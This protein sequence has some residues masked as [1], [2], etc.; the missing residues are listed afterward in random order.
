MRTTLNLPDGLVE[1]LAALSG[2]SRK[3]E[4]V[5]S[6]LREYGLTLRRRRLLRLRGRSELMATDFDAVALRDAEAEE[7]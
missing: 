5:V 4:I 7:I 1:E 6:A 3:T 2:K